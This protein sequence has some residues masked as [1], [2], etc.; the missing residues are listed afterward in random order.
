MYC[1]THKCVF[2]RHAE[3]A[4][5]NCKFFPKLPIIKCFSWK[6]DDNMS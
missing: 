5:I 4:F 3:R 6:N 1:N 2:E